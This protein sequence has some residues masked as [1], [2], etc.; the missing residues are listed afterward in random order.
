MVVNYE[1]MLP[2]S[3][4]LFENRLKIYVYTHKKS[5]VVFSCLTPIHSRYRPYSG[6]AHL[7]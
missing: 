2:P 6:F 5:A 3:S 4:I 7:S 1:Q